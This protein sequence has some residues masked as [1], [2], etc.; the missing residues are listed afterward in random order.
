MADPLLILDRVINNLEQVAILA[1]LDNSDSPKRD[2]FSRAAQMFGS[3]RPGWDAKLDPDDLS[4]IPIPQNVN[5]IFP[6]DAL[7]V[8]LFDNDRLMDLLLSPNY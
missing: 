6:P 2:V 3:L 8:E 1:G 4:T 5:E 7:A